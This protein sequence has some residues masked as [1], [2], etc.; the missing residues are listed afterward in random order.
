MNTFS[1]HVEIR[2]WGTLNAWENAN[3]VQF[4]TNMHLECITKY[5]QVFTV[6]GQIEKAYCIYG[7]AK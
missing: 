7:E 2:F 4:L 5:T 6:F 1:R 3:H